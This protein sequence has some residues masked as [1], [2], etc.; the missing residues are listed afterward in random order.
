[1]IDPCV[2]CSRVRRACECQVSCFRDGFVSQVIYLCGTGAVSNLHDRT[3]ARG[4]RIRGLFSAN[5]GGSFA[6]KQPI[7]A[8]CKSR[9]CIGEPENGRCK[10]VKR[11]TPAS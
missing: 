3:R 4:A 6:R 11:E 1:M 5:D 8:Q 7:D 10:T 9:V 2:S